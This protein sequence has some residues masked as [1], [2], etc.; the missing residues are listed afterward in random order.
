MS[1][2][3]S[4]NNLQ[5]FLIIVSSLA[6]L[7][8]MT[9]PMFSMF[10]QAPPSNPTVSPQAAKN[11]LKQVAQ[12]YEKVL[13][14][15]PDNPTALQGLAEVRLKMGDLSGAIA[16]MEKLVKLYPQETQLKQLLDAIKYQVKTGKKPPLPGQNNSET[17]PKP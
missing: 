10:N 14:R 1:E 13:E 3:S 17:L 7:G 4:K 16:P 9:I 15:E 11:N 6:F 5:K 2:N 12:G 8:T